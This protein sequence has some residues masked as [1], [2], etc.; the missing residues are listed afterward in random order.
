MVGRFSLPSIDSFQG[1]QQFSGSLLHQRQPLGRFP[2][3]DMA[4]SWIFSLSSGIYEEE[5]ERGNDRIGDSQ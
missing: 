5:R 3:S 4:F 2:S 1:T